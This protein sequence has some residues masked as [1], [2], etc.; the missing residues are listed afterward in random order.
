MTL[1][2]SGAK[3]GSQTEKRFSPGNQKELPGGK[4][5]AQEK[6]AIQGGGDGEKFDGFSTVEGNGLFGKG[7][8]NQKRT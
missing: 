3:K 6:G 1:R 4:K 8:V 5:W 7:G 2:E